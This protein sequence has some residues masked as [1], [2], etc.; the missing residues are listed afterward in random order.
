MFLELRKLLKRKTLHALYAD[1]MIFARDI[2]IALLKVSIMLFILIYAAFWWGGGTFL[3]PEESKLQAYLG[4]DALGQ[5]QTRRYAPAE[6]TPRGLCLTLFGQELSRHFLQPGD[7]RRSLHRA[8]LFY[9]LSPRRV[10]CTIKSKVGCGNVENPLEYNIHLL[11]CLL[12][13][14]TAVNR[15]CYLMPPFLLS[16]SG[17]HYSQC[18]YGIRK[19]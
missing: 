7:R 9:C 13:H 16:N 3:S 2:R 10:L 5:G 4:G 11:C 17:D 18:I 8:K 14:Q 15:I 1:S 6:F 19:K 12:S